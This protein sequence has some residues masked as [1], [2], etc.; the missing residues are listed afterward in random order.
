MAEKETI[1]VKVNESEEV[2]HL[3]WTARVVI[4]DLWHTY[5][6]LDRQKGLLWDQLHRLERALGLKDGYQVRGLR[7]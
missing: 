7:K 4:E 3:Q 5:A 2:E 1:E 6:E